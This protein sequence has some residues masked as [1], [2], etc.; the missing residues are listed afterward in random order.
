[1]D[2]GATTVKKFLVACL[3]AAAFAGA[4]AMAA[5][6][7]TKAPV[8]PAPVAVGGFFGELLGAY[9]F[10]DP[11]QGW[12]QFGAGSGT[13]ST[14]EVGIGTGWNGKAVVG[15]RWSA[16]DV[17]FADE[18]GKFT[19]G[20]TTIATGGFSPATISAKMQAYD[21]QLG[22]NTMW[23][24]TATRWALGVR[25]AKWNTTAVD[26]FSRFMYDDWKGIGPRG[27]LQTK[28]P[29]A[30]GW[31]LRGDLALAVLFGTIDVSS[32]PNWNCSQCVSNSTT[33]VNLD[34]SLGVGY[35]IAPGADVV[36]GWKMEYWSAVNV[37]TQDNSSFGAN[38]GTTGYLSHGPFASLKLGI[39][40]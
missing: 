21:A 3:G 1:M 8:A 31:T 10:K 5:D 29:L 32:S 35:T 28:T 23:G 34:A 27:E 19:D 20:D 18:Y 39:A 38:I 15:Y 40:P 37:Q 25:Y 14:P 11:I 26:I 6:M 36:L 2:W 13:V 9:D 24:S 30:P 33:T 7:P 16:W 17:A 4:P 22:Y 12:Q